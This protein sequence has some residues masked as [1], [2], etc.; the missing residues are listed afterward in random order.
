MFKKGNKA[1]PTSRR[2]P[3]IRLD[4]PRFVMTASCPSMVRVK[5]HFR[6]RYVLLNNLQDFLAV[7]LVW[8]PEGRSAFPLKAL[9]CTALLFRNFRCFEGLMFSLRIL[10]GK[11]N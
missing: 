6:V 11:V 1:P 3:S 8:T 4:Q 10:K 9:L 2:L 7:R 5:E